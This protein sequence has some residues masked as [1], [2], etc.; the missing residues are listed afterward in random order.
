LT[1]D[2]P[3]GSVAEMRRSAITVLHSATIERNS[4][5]GR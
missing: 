2:R 3:F 5:F 4:F 1:Y